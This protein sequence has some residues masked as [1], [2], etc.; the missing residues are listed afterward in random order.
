LTMEKNTLL[1]VGV[2][3]VGLLFLLTR[4]SGAQSVQSG[5]PGMGGQSGLPQGAAN[6]TASDVAQ[7]ADALFRIG[8][9]AAETYGAVRGQ[10]QGGAPAAGG[11]AAAAAAAGAQAAATGARG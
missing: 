1:I 9:G 5:L 3:G 4:N 8:R 7:W 10:L 2:V 6:Q 11:N